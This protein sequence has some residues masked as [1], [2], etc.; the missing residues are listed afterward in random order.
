MKNLSRRD[1]IKLA[2]LSMLSLAARPQ[3]PRLGPG[4][5]PNCDR[6]HTS[7][8][9]SAA[10]KKRLEQAALLFIAPDEASA[11][12]VALNIDF[13]EGRNEHSS[14]MCGPLAISIL[15]SADLLGTW[16][17]P[18]NFWLMNPSDNPRPIE[19]TFPSAV[20]S[21]NKFNSPI[22]KFDFTMFPLVAGDL[23]YLEAGSGD[24][25]E[26]VLVV[27]RVDEQ[28]RAY[29]VTNFFT[30]TGTMIEERLL[31]DPAQPGLGQFAAWADR[32]IRNTLGNVG[33]GGFHVW[34]VRDGRNLEFPTDSASQTL[35]SDLDNLFLSSPGQWFATVKE[36][37]GHNLYQFNP[38]EA[39]HPASTIKVPIALAFYHWLETERIADW[40]TYIAYHGVDGRTYAQLLRAMIVE[41]EEDATQ[42]LV[43]FLGKTYLDETWQGW[44]LTSTHVDPRRSSATDIELSLEKLFRG[45]WIAADHRAHLL[46]LM[47]TYTANDEARIGRLRGELP[48][49]SAIYNKRGSLVE[50]P[51]VVG[52]SAIIGLPATA[53][54]FTLHGVGKNAADYEELEATFDLAIDLFSEF[55]SS[56]A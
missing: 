32:S 42:S 35:R 7:D 51:R 6:P 48:E 34:R 2:S 28:G 41:S 24:T 54:I 14:T 18:K 43:D 9:L 47:A 22:S 13:I 44:G 37:N 26:H 3:L 11:N 8:V 5:P 16:A 10:Q 20:Y 27:N 53:Y 23:V 30:A 50:W 40:E 29:S 36:I 12:Q 38:Y 49:G 4:W 25:F 39:F 45:G 21:W 31:Y 15:Q 55:L 46:D 33:S 17:R 1:F 52:D 19:N 56:V